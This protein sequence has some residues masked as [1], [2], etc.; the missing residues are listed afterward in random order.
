MAD[1]LEDPHT[2]QHSERRRESVGNKPAVLHPQLL[3]D[4]S[5]DSQNTGRHHRDDVD[6][7]EKG[8]EELEFGWTDD[9]SQEQFSHEDKR[10]RVTRDL[11]PRVNTRLSQPD[12]F[13][14]GQVEL[15]H[16]QVEMIEGA[17]NAEGRMCVQDGENGRDE[18]E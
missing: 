14:V 2:S 15:Q 17:G 1:D 3:I 6:Q 8:L 12:H 4:Q 7:V 16:G 11:D 18:D 10:D 9:E 13:G 5:G